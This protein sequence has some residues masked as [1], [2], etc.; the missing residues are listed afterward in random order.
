[1]R[2]VL[3]NL[4]KSVIN[5]IIQ[6]MAQKSNGKNKVENFEYKIIRNSEREL[7]VYQTLYKRPKKVENMCLI[8]KI[9][10]V[11][12]SSAIVMQGQLVQE[13]DFTVETVKFYRKLYPGVLVIVSTWK[14]ENPEII[15][16]L[17][18]MENCEVVLSEYPENAGLLNL[19]FQ[20][21]TTLAGIRLAQKLGKQYILKSRCDYRFYKK[22][23]FE[24]LYCLLQ[25]YPKDA[26]VSYQK[27]RIIAG[28]EVM[29]SMFRPFWLAD[30]FNY[31]Y[32]DDMLAYWDYRM[33]DRNLNKRQVQDILGKEHYT[34]TQRTE[35]QL[36]AEPELVLDY[37]RRYEKKEIDISV[38]TYWEYIRKQF[39]LIS[40]TELEYYWMKY[41]YKYDETASAGLFYEDDHTNKCLTYNWDF[42]TWL[43]LYRNLLSYDEAYEH[44]SKENRY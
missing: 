20:V 7:D 21:T 30:Q 5:K 11:N 4:E 39:I 41:E 3:K 43:L 17:R 14:D 22:K 6:S 10:D 12:T 42:S 8:E 26:S 13:D 1:M 32:V 33:T 18:Q 40:R 36:A 2:N 24:Y 19:N 9:S 34:W 28:A 38:E 16:R 31:G 44:F 25:E 27:F 15:Q 23:M 29:D 35:K 37:L